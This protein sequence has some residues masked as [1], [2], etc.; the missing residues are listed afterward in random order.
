MTV[1]LETWQVGPWNRWAYLHVG[2]VVPTVA[3]RRDTGRRWELPSEDDGA[4]DDL[5]A[6]LCETAY[7][8]G[9]AV[10]RDGTFVL[11]RYANGMGADTRHLSQSVGKSVLGLLVGVL[12]ERGAL[13]PDAAVADLVPE[14]AASGYAGAT[15]Q[16]LL[17]MTAAIDF[18]EDYAVDF[19]RYDVACGW[20]PPH[21]DV[22]AGSIL[23]FLPTIGPAAWAHG[24]RF[25]YAS[26]NTD[27][28][29]I[30]AERAGG[31]PLAELIATHLWE[32]LGAEHDA[33]VTV[34]PA[35]TGVIS[36]GFCAS[37][38]DYS[39][40]GALVAA[41]GRGIVPERWA[42]TLGHGDP[43]AF[44]RTTVPDSTSGT[45]GYGTQ[46]WHRDGGPVAR[47]IHGQMIAV[48]RRAGVIVTIL[49]SWP[50]AMDPALEATHRRFVA[51][52]RARLA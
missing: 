32:P 48:D 15:L 34:D 5:A 42:A 41:G 12:A 10:V 36:G 37:L 44:A 46:W 17:D 19:W 38:R 28:L 50:Y 52:V 31:A 21:P 20:H 29:G 18:V 22:E 45:D 23:E 35:G 16:H 49:S 9:V 13:H 1:P 26:P 24:A 30:A 7:A 40:L 11:E 33:E 39:R 51:D 43:S 4:L 8:D 47:G 6:A 2:E 25:H 27:L 3:V 14:V